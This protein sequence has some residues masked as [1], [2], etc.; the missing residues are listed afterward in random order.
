MTDLVW[1]KKL[2]EWLPAFLAEHAA[3]APCRAACSIALHGSLMLGLDDPFADYDLWLLLG[4]EELAAL[5]ARSPTRFFGFR[6]DGREGHLIAISLSDF[7]N[8]IARCDMDTLFQLRRAAI[9]TDP[10]GTLAEQQRIALSPMPES[11]RKTFAKYHYIEMRRDHRA[12]DNPMERH[13]A[14]A[15]L[16]SLPKTMAHALRAAMILDAEPYP[17]DKW[18]YHTARHTPTGLRLEP[19][20]DRIVAF[21]GSGLLHFE[22][23][24]REHPIS[25][26][27]RVIRQVLI[28]ESNRKGCGGE[29]LQS[30]WLFLDESRQEMA[31]VRWGKS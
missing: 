15:V 21:L 22:G 6:L 29:W 23:R 25:Q 8:R 4:D 30:W 24:E 11:V 9:V 28:D 27:L 19:S 17:Y 18:L 14:V 2:R 31:N 3:L 10:D 20:I 1:T 16:L 26:E 5:D 12:C 7:S 13:D